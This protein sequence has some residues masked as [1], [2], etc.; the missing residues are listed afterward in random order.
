MRIQR[1]SVTSSTQRL[2]RSP[3]RLKDLK[4]K[5]GEIAESQRKGEIAEVHIVQAPSAKQKEW[6]LLF[7]ERQG[8]SHFLVTDDEKVCSYSSVDAAIEALR[9]LGFKRAEIMF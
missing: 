8:Y 1:D 9:T 4:V 2:P 7:K 3:P 5:K 6:I